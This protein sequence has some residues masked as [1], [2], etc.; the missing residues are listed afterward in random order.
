MC[1]KRLCA[2]AALHAPLPVSPQR[3]RRVDPRLT[4][5]SQIVL[6]GND[7]GVRHAS[8]RGPDQTL[9]EIRISS[10]I[11]IF[12]GKRQ[13]LSADGR[14]PSVNCVIVV[15]SRVYNTVVIVIVGKIV[16]LPACVK[17]K[18]QHFHPR[19]FC[20]LH[21][22]Q[23]TRCQKSQILRDHLAV[24]ESLLHGF[25]QLVSRPF[26]PHAMLRRLILVRDRPVLVK[27]PE[28]V[29]AHDVVYVK[30][31]GK[32]SD[33]PRKPRL[34]MVR[35]PV[36]G[37]APELPGSG[38][39]I[40]RAPCN[41]DGD[42]CLIEPEKLGVRPRICTVECHIDR[43]VS[44]DADP[45]FVG[46]VFERAPLLGEQI[47]LVAVKCDIVSE[48]LLIPCHSL[49][50]PE[51]DILAPLNPRHAL[52]RILDRHVHRIV[53]QPLLI[54]ADKRL[55]FRIRPEICPLKSPAEKLEPC[56][57][58]F[59]VRHLPGIVSKVD[60][61]ALLLR[62]EPLLDQRIQADVIRAARKSRKRLVR[63]IPIPCRSQ[64]QDLPQC[65][66]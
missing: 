57:V 28:M 20:L 45:F 43:D 29:D 30:T 10:D 9:T 42:I 8:E 61:Q 33:P 51:T 64:R 1:R 55:V 27:T 11:Q 52:Q 13:I 63:R 44:H 62:E 34:L 25:K 3:R 24:P 31:V 12:P 53:F 39:R 50:L 18:L 19:K 15:C 49:R 5:E 46:V 26:L 16:A 2:R 60:R 48:L 4:A 36:Q 41:L 65:L 21:K 47:L 7:R 23:H 35:P 32:P 38:E 54:F 40:R 59:L 37:I 66:S 58:Y 6:H 56:V 14:D 22:F 17:R